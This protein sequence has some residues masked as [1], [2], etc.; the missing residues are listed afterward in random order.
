MQRART[1]GSQRVYRWQLAASQIPCHQRGGAAAWW[2][3]RSLD[4]QPLSTAE[5]TIGSIRPYADGVAVYAPVVAQKGS[6]TRAELIAA[7]LAAAADGPV[8]IAT[9]SAALIL[10]AN[11]IKAAVGGK[12]RKPVCW[13]TTKDG[14]MWEVF[15]HIV[16]DKG[17]H[18]IR[19]VKVK[20]HAEEADVLSGV[21]TDRNKKGNG[22]AD[23][24]AGEAAAIIGKSKLDLLAAYHKRHWD[25][26]AFIVKVT[27]HNSQFNNRGIETKPYIFYPANKFEIY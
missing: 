27:K 23:E 1:L 18:A 4:E 19:F 20:A 17:N 22:K 9:D 24:V 11:A 13:K 21:T 3:N 12:L 16:E 14:D 2:P 7:I 25:Y 6:S 8:T 5:R 10:K 15:G 26:V